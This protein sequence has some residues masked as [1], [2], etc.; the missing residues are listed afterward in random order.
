MEP[1]S[2]LNSRGCSPP[3]FQEVGDGSPLL[4]TSF[5]ITSKTQPPWN[6][7]YSGGPSLYCRA[8]AFFSMAHVINIPS[9]EILQVYKPLI[10][11]QGT[12]RVLGLGTGW[13]PVSDLTTICSQ[14]VP[15]HLWPFGVLCPCVVPSQVG[16]FWVIRSQVVPGEGAMRFLHLLHGFI[17]TFC[18]PS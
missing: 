8:L 1:F 2:G 5:R 13:P 16:L 3:W 18:G 15:S 7:C 6:F 10:V 14:A 17:H 11:L 4:G 9:R 12:G